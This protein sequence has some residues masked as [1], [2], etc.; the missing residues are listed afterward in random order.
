[1]KLIFL[2]SNS[3]IVGGGDYFVYK[4]AEY[5]A[6]RGNKITIFATTK[7]ASY[8]KNIPKLK[9]LTVNSSGA[10]PKIFKGAGFLNRL[11]TNVYTKI[12]IESF[13]KNGE[14]IDFL[15]GYHRED[16][17]M[18]SKLAKKYEKPSATF[19]FET[20]Q[21]MESRLKGRWNH[22]YRGRFKKSWLLTKES[23]KI[24]DIIFPISNLTKEENQK[25]INR[26]IE[27][28]IY[29]GFDKDI[30]DKVHVKKRNQLIYIGRLNAYKN[31]DILLE[32]VSRI[33]TAPKLI[34]C[35]DGEER[36]NLINLAKKLNVNCEFKYEIPGKTKWEEIKRSL[37]MVFPTSF[38]GF[39]MPPMEALYCGIP[40]ICSDIPIL[41]EVYKDKV[42]YFEDGN[43]NDLRKK[44]LFLL[45]NPD[46]CK[47]RGVEGRN[48]I[49]SRY[50][51]EKSA[52]KV[53]KI[54]LR[55]KNEKIK[56]K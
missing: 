9:N 22:E 13:L 2:L 4:I 30:I 33:S 34:I 7:K 44:I 10:I 18:V 26:V 38:E 35:G 55:H 8:L 25:W 46:Y 43:S 53:E 28:P 29:P 36:T 14:D 24:I 37:F 39:G 49:K 52:R 54:L 6:R 56:N 12:I 21:W 31:I 32:A 19:V 11:W 17:I 48:F 20:P 40:C 15:I 47:K 16:T 23:L 1:M 3:R 42:E 50:S 5:L 51:W 27:S 41:R 45:N